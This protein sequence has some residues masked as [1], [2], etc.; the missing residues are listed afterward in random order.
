MRDKLKLRMKEDELNEYKPVMFVLSKPDLINLA[1]ETQS[2]ASI[3]S[4]S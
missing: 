1:P 2:T 4:V 3:E